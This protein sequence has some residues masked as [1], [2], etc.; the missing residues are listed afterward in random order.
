MIIKKYLKIC[1][2]NTMKK[3]ISIIGLLLIISPVFSQ[4]KLDNAQMFGSARGLAF[5]HYEL[6]EVAQ[7]IVTHEFTFKNNELLDINIV[8]VYLPQG[9][10]IMIPKKT[11]QPN[12]EGKIIA[13]VYKE[14]VNLATDENIL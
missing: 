1:K 3:L 13:T 6:S 8:S 9:I 11:I 14:Y 2:K 7:D 5:N 12:E 4:Q 10:S